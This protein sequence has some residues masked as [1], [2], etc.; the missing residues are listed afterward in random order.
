MKLMSRRSLLGFIGLSP[1]AAIAVARAEYEDRTP[2]ASKEL[3]G[4]IYRDY[5]MF[6]TGWKRSQSSDLLVGQWIGYPVYRTPL[7][8]KYRPDGMYPYLVSSVP[9]AASAYVRG[10]CFNICLLEGQVYTT[11]KTSEPV[12]DAESMKGKKRLIEMIDSVRTSGMKNLEIGHWNDLF[13]RRGIIPKPPF[14]QEA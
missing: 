5:R 4:E 13:M 1:L 14:W 3:G 11:L 12:K 10:D 6:F 9:G 7:G 2:Q 8:I